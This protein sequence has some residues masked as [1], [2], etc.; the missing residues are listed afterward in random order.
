M[1]A[2]C[3]LALEALKELIACTIVTKFYGKNYKV[4][5]KDFG[6]DPELTEEQ[7]RELGRFFEWADELLPWLN[8]RMH[9]HYLTT[10]FY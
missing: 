1:T 10:L 7:D 3:S 4:I 8:H 9:V 5:R 6:I 2:A